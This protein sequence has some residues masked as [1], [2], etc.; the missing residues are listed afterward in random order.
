MYATRLSTVLFFVLP[1]LAIPDGMASDAAI[2]ELASQILKVT[3]VQ[4]GLIVH[5]GCGDG[6][7]TAAFRANDRFLVHG[8][9]TD[10]A[11]IQRARENVF[12]ACDYGEVSVA[13]YD[14]QH[15]PY[16]EN[17]VNLLVASRLDRVEMAEVM[18][19]LVP[20]GVAYVNKDGTGKRVSS[21]G[22]RKWANGRIICMVRTETP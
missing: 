22:R 1:C 14:G 18:R 17:M 8:L 7:L 15:L 4:G 2:E 9:D 5:L 19:V 11:D 13:V 16:A 21:P 3:G 12:Q 20:G 6:S 10:S